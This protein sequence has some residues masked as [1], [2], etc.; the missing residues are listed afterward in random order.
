MPQQYKTQTLWEVFGPSWFYITYFVV[1]NLN[2]C[3]VL[4]TLLSIL[5][6]RSHLILPQTLWSWY[7][8]TYFGG[9]ETKSAGL[10]F[11]RSHSQKWKARDLSFSL[12]LRMK[13]VLLA[14]LLLHPS[15][16]AVHYNILRWFLKSEILQAALPLCKIWLREKPQNLFRLRD[17]VRNPL[18]ILLWQCFHSPFF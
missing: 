2:T 1:K 10:I 17:L 18:Q 4:G 9:K 5:L 16:P 7:F 14:S 6:I 8:C 15:D 11:R 12:E 3:Q 13:S